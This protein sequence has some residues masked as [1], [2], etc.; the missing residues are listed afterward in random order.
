MQTASLPE[1]SLGRMALQFVTFPQSDPADLSIASVRGT[2]V[3]A[4]RNVDSWFSF[5]RARGLKVDTVDDPTVHVY[6]NVGAGTV[7]LRGSAPLH[8]ASACRYA[9][10]GHRIPAAWE[11]HIRAWSRYD[12]KVL[13]FFINF[14]SHNLGREHNPKMQGIQNAGRTSV[15][16]PDPSSGCNHGDMTPNVNGWTAYKCNVINQYEHAFAADFVSGQ[17]LCTAV[18]VAGAVACPHSPRHASLPEYTTPGAGSGK[19]TFDSDM[20]PDAYLNAVAQAVRAMDDAD[21]RVRRKLVDNMRERPFAGSGKAAYPAAYTQEVYRSRW[22]VAMSML[23]TQYAGMPDDWIWANTLDPLGEAGGGGYGSGDILNRWVEF[24]FLTNGGTLAAAGLPELRLRL[25]A[26][27]AAGV[28]VAVNVEPGNSQGWATGDGAGGTTWAAF[29][30]EVISRGLV[31]RILVCCLRSYIFD[32]PGL[33][34]P[35]A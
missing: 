31:D 19:M 25:D 6:H 27:R 1:T 4:G 16:V 23:R 13:D 17:G 21:G 32:Q 7:Q 15:L 10:F 35:L 24:F 26:I 22:R 12:T 33:F 8:A 29:V 30:P 18:Y 28:R 11:D 20:R 2:P 34:E 3:T 9:G 5:F 14:E